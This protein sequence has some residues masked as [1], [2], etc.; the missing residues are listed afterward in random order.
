[1]SNS[2]WPQG[3]QHAKLCSLIISLSLPQLM[4]IASVIPSNHLILRCPFLLLPSIFLII[5]VFSNESAPP[6]IASGGQSMVASASILSMNILGWLSL[7]LTGLISFLYK[8]CSRVFSSTT[9]RKHQFLGA[10][11]SLWPNSNV[12]TCQLEKPKQKH[13]FDYTDLCWKSDVS[14]Q[15]EDVHFYS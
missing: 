3:L 11:P 9:V 6:P 7:R 10:Q 1:M 12:H 13:S 15:V 14:Y 8:G 2:S 5:R 4:S